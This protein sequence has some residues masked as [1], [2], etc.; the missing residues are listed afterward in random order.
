VEGY[1]MNLQNSLAFL[2]NNN[3]QIIKEYIEKNPFTLAQKKI[4]YL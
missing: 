4:K 3:E 1:K 2:Y